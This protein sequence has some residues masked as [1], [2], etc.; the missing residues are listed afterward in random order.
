[1]ARYDLYRKRGKSGIPEPKSSIPKYIIKRACSGWVA[2]Y[3]IWNLRQNSY[4]ICH[5]DIPLDDAEVL[6]QVKH[7]TMNCDGLGPLRFPTAISTNIHIFAILRT[8][9]LVHDFNSF[10]QPHYTSAVLPVSI[11]PA[12]HA[13]TYSEHISRQY[14][15][16][17][18][19]HSHD[20]DDW[21]PHY[22]IKFSFEGQYLCFRDCTTLAILE[23]SQKE[24]QCSVSILSFLPRPVFREIYCL[25]RNLPLLA[26]L[27]ESTIKLWDFT[28][29][30]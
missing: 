24:E 26:F 20:D 2:T 30:R 11:L 25:H 19:K 27:S 12:Y 22:E 21:V 7:I 14:D 5:F 17:I 3:E 1:M 18:G 23:V 10:A 16:V 13:P 9:Y 6:S 28:H 8:I 15:T 4:P 29:G